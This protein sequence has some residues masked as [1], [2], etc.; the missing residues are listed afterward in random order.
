M[1]LHEKPPS[2]NGPP[3]ITCEYLGDECGHPNQA[4]FNSYRVWTGF[5]P[6]R[7]SPRVPDLWLLKS[8]IVAARMRHLI[9]VRFAQRLVD[10]SKCWEA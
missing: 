10:L 1:S 3:G 4:E 5:R 8:A 9:S 7:K 6:W 2:R